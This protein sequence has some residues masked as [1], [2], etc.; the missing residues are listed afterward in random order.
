MVLKLL[1]KKVLSD[2]MERGLPVPP[3]SGNPTI[4]IQ[5]EEKTAA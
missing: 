2:I 1:K 4:V 5:N 3:K